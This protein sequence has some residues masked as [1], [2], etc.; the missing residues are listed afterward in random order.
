MH[1]K[2]ISYLGSNTTPLLPTVI[3]PSA[4][5]VWGIMSSL[6][7]VD[8]MTHRTSER[9]PWYLEDRWRFHKLY[10]PNIHPVWILYQ[11]ISSAQYSASF[12]EKKTSQHCISSITM[13]SFSLYL[14]IFMALWAAWIC[15]KT[16][17][18]LYFHP[19]RRVPGPRLAAATH[20]Y[21]FYFDVILAGKFILQMEKMH[22]KYG[23]I[24]A[25]RLGFGNF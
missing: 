6:H 17:H 19:L 18:R 2:S 9:M 5:C 16:V 7:T 15:L 14:E 10:S 8:M 24:P 1:G 12:F 11:F 22:E 4:S 21:E 20:L 25:R 23:T 3:H 13:W